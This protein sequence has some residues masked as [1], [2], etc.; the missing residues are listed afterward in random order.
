MTI[1]LGGNIQLSGFRDLDSATMV[2]V[3]KIVGNFVKHIDSVD[4]FQGLHVTLKIIHQREKSEIYELNAKLQSDKLYTSQSVD[5][6]LM[7]GLDSVLKKV[8]RTM[9][10]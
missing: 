7:I 2:V 1:E 9:R 4:K 8:E 6:N 3:K 5:R 10:R